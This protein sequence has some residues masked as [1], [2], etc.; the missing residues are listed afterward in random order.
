MV[1]VDANIVAYLLIEGDR[2]TQ[3]RALLKQDGDWHTEPLLFAELANIL[4]TSLRLK[5]LSFEQCARIIARAE[6]LLGSNLHATA[7]VGVLA[8]AN[9][10]HISAYDARYITLARDLEIPLVTEDKKLR[11]AVPGLTRSLSEALEVSL[12]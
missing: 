2:S 6:D 3:A 4:A 1:L 7:N 8:T 10:Y 9:E 5:N 11:A 12:G